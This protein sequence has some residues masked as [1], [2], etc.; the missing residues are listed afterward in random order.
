MRKITIPAE[1]VLNFTD[2]KGVERARPYKWDEFVKTLC[3]DQRFMERMKDVYEA[4]D[5]RKKLLEQVDPGQEFELGD[6]D[7]SVLAE[8]AK[9]PPVH[10]FVIYQIEDYLRAVT[11][12]PVVKPAAKPA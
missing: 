10:P 2:D 8:I 5:L 12:A 7:W 4:I 3:N 9:K 6:S 11:D 1:G